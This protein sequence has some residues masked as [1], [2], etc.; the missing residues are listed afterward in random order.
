MYTG[1]LI[2]DL[3]RSV[4]RADDQTEKEMQ[5][6]EAKLAYWYAAAQQELARFDETLQGAA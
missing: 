6:H 3:M 2:D 4:E 1:T 5:L